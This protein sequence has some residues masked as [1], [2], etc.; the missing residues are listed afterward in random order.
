MISVVIPT[1]NAQTRLTR[2]FDSLI[3]AA[4]RGVV[5]EVIV[6]DGGST[7]DT[8]FLADAAGARVVRAGNW[9]SA[10][11]AEGAKVAKSD[12]LLFLPPDAVLEPGWENEAEAFIQRSVLERPQAA[13]FRVAVD[14]FGAVARVREAAATLRCALFALPFGEQGLLIPKRLYQK[15]GGYRN[16][17]T[18][19]DVDIARR[20]G[21]R[22]LVMLRTRAIVSSEGFHRRSAG[23]TLLSALKVPA[24][25]LSRIYR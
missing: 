17:S 18:M 5:R 1:L 21:R 11:L 4:V 9:R 15:I 2:C 12:W 23:M 19:E 13:V 8:L 22:R 14:A 16:L 20:V 3:G 7:D 24:S 6:A 25:V 10:Q